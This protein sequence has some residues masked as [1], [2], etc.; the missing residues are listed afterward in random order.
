MT[1]ETNARSQFRFRL[2][3]FHDS[4][5]FVEAGLLFVWVTVRDVQPE[6]RP[7]VTRKI[8][9]SFESPQ[10]TRHGGQAPDVTDKNQNIKPR[11]NTN[12]HELG[13]QKPS[14]RNCCSFV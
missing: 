11:M 13:R 3:V 6:I 14:A 9:K 8:R 1:C 12:S 7:E 2:F 4:T 5:L 10:I